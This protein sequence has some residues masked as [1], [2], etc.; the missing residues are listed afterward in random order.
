[1]QGAPDFRPENIKEGVSLWNKIGT[2]KAP[3]VTYGTVTVQGN[4][5]GTITMIDTGF[6]EKPTHAGI[7][8]EFPLYGNYSGYN[9][10]VTIYGNQIRVST[11]GMPTSTV[12]W[13]AVVL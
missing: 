3:K 4:P 1:M 13:V 8:G 7:T 12:N 2:L 5:S 9:V 10:S 11:D 6:S